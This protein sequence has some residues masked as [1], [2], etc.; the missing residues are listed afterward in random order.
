MHFELCALRPRSLRPTVWPAPHAQVP[1]DGMVHFDLEAAAT[2]AQLADDLVMQC[3][4]DVVCI[5]AGRT[6]VGF[7]V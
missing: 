6:W 1:C 3:R 2:D 7:T 5:C 4:P